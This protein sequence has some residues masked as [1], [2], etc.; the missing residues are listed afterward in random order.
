[1]DHCRNPVGVL[2]FCL[3]NVFAL[4]FVRLVSRKNRFLGFDFESDAL[5]NAV[6][7]QN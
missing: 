2:A 6:S 7:R 1:V 4:L 5:C 3:T